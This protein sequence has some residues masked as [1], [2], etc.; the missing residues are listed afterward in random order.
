MTLQDV[1]KMY[2]PTNVC[3]LLFCLQRPL[4]PWFALLL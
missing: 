3:I 2:S 1:Y 4:K